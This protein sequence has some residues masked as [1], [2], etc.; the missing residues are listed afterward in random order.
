MHAWHDTGVID[1]ILA[2]GRLP[3][4]AEIAMRDAIV[5]ALARGRLTPRALVDEA[6]M[7][8]ERRVARRFGNSVRP[9]LLFAERDRVVRELR[10]FIDGR[11]AAR[12]GALHRRSVVATGAAAAPFDAIVRNRRGNAFGVVFRRM[13]PDGRRLELLR[14]ARTALQTARTPID[15]VLLYDF[16]RGSSKLVSDQSGAD[17]V[18]RYLRAS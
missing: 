18:H 6:L 4:L 7:R 5:Q 12:L 14:R 2:A 17:R 11:L 1:P 16:V 9:A 3:R 15:G 8:F 10:A 13:P